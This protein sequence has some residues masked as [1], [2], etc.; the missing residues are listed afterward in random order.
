MVHRKRDITVMKRDNRLLPKLAHKT[1]RGFVLL[2]HAVAVPRADPILVFGNQKSGTTAIA[3]LLAEATSESY[4][5][6]MLFHN[7]WKTVQ[8]IY[9]GEMD[10]REVRRRLRH[11]FACKIIKDPDLTLLMD[12]A[13][14]L[15]PQ[16][17]AVYVV[18]E[19]A[20]NIRSILSRL[21]IRGDKPALE[22]EDHASLE[23]LPLWWDVLHPEGEILGGEAQSYIETLAHRW[24]VMTSIAA[25]HDDWAVTIRYE[26][27]M[28][29]KVGEISQ[30]ARQIGLAP[31][32]DISD[33]V[34]HAFQEPGSSEAVETFFGADN[35]QKIWSICG[36]N[37]VKYGYRHSFS[38]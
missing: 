9:R 13:H 12:E 16:A 22:A 2:K 25:A 27:F 3:R 1:R 15:L 24:R 30:L 28:A 36:K 29:D 14:T 8:P 5:H 19:P 32:G 10:L 6:D 20:A 38:L 37:A 21:K 17:R 33:R 11:E 35:L 18:R 7:Q 31:R 4:S 34:D 23:A 26:D